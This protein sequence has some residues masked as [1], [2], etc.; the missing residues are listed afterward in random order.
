MCNYCDRVQG[1]ILRQLGFYKD[2][3]Q[4]AICMLMFLHK[5][6]QTELYDEMISKCGIHP[7]EIINGKC[8]QWITKDY[9]NIKPNGPLDTLLTQFTLQR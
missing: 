8:V 1:I 7:K 4:G 6:E 9:K 3:N 2:N 5:K